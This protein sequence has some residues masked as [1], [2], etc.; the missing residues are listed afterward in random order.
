MADKKLV[1]Q[2]TSREVDFAQWYTDV[3]KKAE[4]KDYSSVKGLSDLPG[5]PSG[6]ESRKHWIHGLRQPVYRTV[7][8]RS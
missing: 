5:M 7:R 4:L 1:E 8:C 3:V 6:R 2:I